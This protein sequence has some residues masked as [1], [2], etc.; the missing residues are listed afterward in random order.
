MTFELSNHD[1]QS[2]Y[3]LQEDKLLSLTSQKHLSKNRVNRDVLLGKN[4]VLFF[5]G[6]AMKST[7]RH[8]T[9]E[10]GFDTSSILPAWLWRWQFHHKHHHSSGGRYYNDFYYRRVWTMLPR[11]Q[12]KL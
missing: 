8:E 11:W 5:V 1:S 6:D 9:L 7:G 4:N 12:C 2:I 10:F 3:L